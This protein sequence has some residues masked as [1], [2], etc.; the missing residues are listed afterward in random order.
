M[1]G[2]RVREPYL[3]SQ[4]QSGR[5]VYDDDGDLHHH[6]DRHEDEDW[7]L[8]GSMLNPQES[9]KLNPTYWGGFRDML[10]TECMRLVQRRSEEFDQYDD[11]TDELER[12]ASISVK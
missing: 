3:P 10:A 2:Y 8:H 11:Y 12:N 9:Y 7:A 6:R 4:G 5:V 1:T